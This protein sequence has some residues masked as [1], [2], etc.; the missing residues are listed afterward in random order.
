[1]SDD[2]VVKFPGS[3]RRPADGTGLRTPS[4][5]SAGASAPAT[6][7]APPSG[8]AGQEPLADAAARVLIRDALDDT[9]V[10]EAAAGTG[11]TT[12]LVARIVQLIAQGK[13]EIQQIVAVTFTEKA[14]GELKLRIREELEKA[15]TSGSDPLGLTQMGQ[16]PLSLRDSDFTV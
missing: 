4:A 9:L 7:E 16:T 15:R 6:R 14:A 10:V 13:A 1:M 5:G 3:E 11:K 2:K 12:E 8:A